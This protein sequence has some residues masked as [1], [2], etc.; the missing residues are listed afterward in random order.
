MTKRERVCRVVRRE[1]VDY[2]PSQITFS[3][4]T[5]DQTIHDALGLAADVTLDDYLENHIVISLIKQDYPLFLRND[6]PLMRSL[7]AEGFCTVDEEGKVVYDN[8]GMGIQVGEDGFF[9]CFHPLEQQQTEEFAER[10]MPERIREAV[11]R[12]TLEERIALWTPPDP[13]QATNFDLM[14]NDIATYGQEMFVLP[15]GYFGLYERAYGMTSIPTTLELTITNPPLLRDLLEKIT[16]YKVG[17]ARR[18]V[19]MD[20]DC[21]HM[22]DD[23]GTQTGPFFAPESFHELIVPCYRR[24]WG[25]YKDA[26]KL[27]SMHSCGKIID[28]LPTLVELGLDILE[29][30]QPCND[31]EWIK[32]EFGDRLTFWGGI[33]TQQLLPFGSADEVREESRRVIRTLGRGGG[34]IIAPSQEIMNDVPLTN[35]VALLETIQEERASVLGK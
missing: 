25:V 19:E 13:D 27:M 29:P 2:L 31:L 1:E 6:I 26:G 4:R 9:A 10:W 17:V 30:V 16:D 34:H 7:E 5:R 14:E 32:S 28:F 12:P 22:G 35:I 21:G 33:D 8:W 3:D 18:M 11:T 24:L 20:I 23:L 15:S